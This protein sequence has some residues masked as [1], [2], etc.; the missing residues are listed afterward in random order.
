[1]RRRPL[2]SLG[3]LVRDKRGRR[4]LREVAAEIGIGPA[5]LLRVESG[6]VPD[7]ST[8][9]KLCLWLGRDP[10]EFLGGPTPAGEAPAA[11]AGIVISA[12]LRADRTPQMETMQALASMLLL[13]A[14]IQ[15]PAAPPSADERT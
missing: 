5:T 11:I 8:F 3:G 12:H 10:R 6:R 9:G 13:A 14:R 15:P 4:T 7:V 2:E 1:M